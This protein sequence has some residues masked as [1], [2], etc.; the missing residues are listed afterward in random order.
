M[1][2]DTWKN[3][4][5]LDKATSASM[6]SA[7][8]ETSDYIEDCLKVTKGMLITDIDDIKSEITDLLRQ[9]TLFDYVTGPALYNTTNV[10]PNAIKKALQSKLKS[11][12]N[13]ELKRIVRYQDVEEPK[14]KQS[15]VQKEKP[16]AREKIKRKC[17]KVV[18]PDSNNDW[19]QGIT[20]ICLHFCRV[21]LANFSTFASFFYYFTEEDKLQQVPMIAKLKP[22]EDGSAKDVVFVVI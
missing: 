7:L 9:N 4:L 3:F 11:V 1:S 16:K 21:G 22:T 8:K 2:D 15:I 6:K 12:Y 17:V 10:E 19:N 20:Q 13:R 14:I 18:H 5:G